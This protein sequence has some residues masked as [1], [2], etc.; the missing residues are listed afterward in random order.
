V[1][2]VVRIYYLVLFFYKMKGEKVCVVESQ[3]I[4]GVLITN[5]RNLHFGTSTK[6]GRG[7]GITTKI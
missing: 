6:I 3:I 1:F 2:V 5:G 4:S 7:K